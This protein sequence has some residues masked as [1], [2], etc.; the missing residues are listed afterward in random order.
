MLNIYR[1]ALLDLISRFDF[2]FCFANALV[3]CSAISILLKDA[4]VYF[5]I[6]AVIPSAVVVL[7]SDALPQK[8]RKAG[9][10]NFTFQ[11]HNHKINTS[12]VYFH[13]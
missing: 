1:Q 3:G 8:L 5:F 9:N 13:I 10:K 11:C 4:R 7:A 6:G 2:L 12:W